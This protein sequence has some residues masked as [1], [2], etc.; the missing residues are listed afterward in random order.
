MRKLYVAA[1]SYMVAGLAFGLFYRELTKLS[2]FPEG[3]PTQLA[4][5]HTHLL[6]LG[7]L[8]LLVVLALEKL[9]GL[10]RSRLFGWFFWVYNAG[11]VITA[12][13]MVWH[14]TLTVVGQ[15]STPMIAGIAGMG[16]IVTTVGFVLLFL[17][18]GRSLR[19][20]QTAPAGPLPSEV[21]VG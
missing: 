15:E 18:L 21:A 8:A 13:A 5:V 9:F 20:D 3:S 11:V 7:M 16:H 1:F 14:G 19:R 12:G 10:S 2:D 4:S 17:T 6:A